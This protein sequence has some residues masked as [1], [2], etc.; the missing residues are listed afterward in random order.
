ME[1]HVLLLFDW[2]V[3]KPGEHLAIRCA[4][5]AVVSWFPGV[6][7]Q[8]WIDASVRCSHA[9]RYNDRDGDRHRQTQTD[10]DRHRV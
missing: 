5:V 3:P 2:V 6:L 7:Q 9:E 8:L 1:R 10:T 4:I